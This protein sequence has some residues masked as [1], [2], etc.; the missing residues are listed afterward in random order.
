[1]KR[2]TPERT[3]RD[4]LAHREWFV[5]HARTQIATKRMSRPHA[6]RVYRALTAAIRDYAEWCA[7]RT[8]PEEPEDWRTAA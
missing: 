8:I 5:R 6:V 4:L 1:M 7:D 2:L 3:L